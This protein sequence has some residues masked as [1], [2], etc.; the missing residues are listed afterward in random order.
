MVDPLEQFNPWLILKVEQFWLLKQK[1][2]NY[3]SDIGITCI[4]EETH[5]RIQAQFFFPEYNIRLYDKNSESDY[6]IFPPS[7]SEYFFQQHWESDYFFLEKNHTPPFNKYSN[8]CVVWKK[9]LNETK[10]H[11][12][13]PCKLNG[14][15]LRQMTS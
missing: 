8:S 2:C 6:F 14:R 15:S 12:T 7:K 4:V 1:I 9:I 5:R 10:N 13:P 11:N 3:K